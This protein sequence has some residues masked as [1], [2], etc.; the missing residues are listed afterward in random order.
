MIEDGARVGPYQLHERLGNGASAFVYRAFNEEANRIV[1]IKFLPSLHDPLAVA[2]F[3]REARAMRLLDH[4]NIV[5]VL[6]TG[7][8]EGTPYM[9][10][11]YVEGGTL[12]G[13]LSDAGP[14]P[15]AEA[16]QILDGTAAGLEYAHQLGILHRDIKPDNILLNNQGTPVIADFGLARL[17][18]Q[19]SV[20]ATGILSGTPAYMSPEE[21]NG[22]KVGPA[23]DQYSL[24]A[25]GYQ[26]LTGQVPFPGLT[27]TEVLVGLLTR[28]PDPPSSLRIDLGRDVDDVILRGLDKDPDKRFESCR[29]FTDALLTAISRGAP[30]SIA[31][32]APAVERAPADPRVAGIRFDPGETYLTIVVPRRKV[33]GGGR[34]RVIASLAAAVVLLS[35][36]GAGLVLSRTAWPIVSDTP[37]SAVSVTAPPQGTPSR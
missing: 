4:P 28:E 17:L 36:L 9:V 13:R 29:A 37:A 1:A 5:Q 21:G 16:M 27:V 10:F 32:P 26:L 18:E 3:K 14:L 24:A 7:E 2:R 11:D 34:R 19:P 22:L 12:A 8:H 31:G 33:V 30:V 23:A 25:L 6:D 15:D 35:S 20:T